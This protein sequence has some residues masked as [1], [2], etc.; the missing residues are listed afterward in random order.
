[1]DARAGKGTAGVTLLGESRGRLAGEADV[2]D[3]ERLVGM[4]FVQKVFFV[5]D[6][7]AILGDAVAME[8]GAVVVVVN[9]HRLFAEN[10]GMIRP[11]VFQGPAFRQDSRVPD[12]QAVFID[13]TLSL[14]PISKRPPSALANPQTQRRR[15]SRHDSFHLWKGMN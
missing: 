13:F 5:A 2:D 8:D 11:K 10:G 14:R 12:F 3:I 9:D 15:S 6:V 1:M 4:R 7:C